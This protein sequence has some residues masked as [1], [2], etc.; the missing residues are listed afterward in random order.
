MRRNHADSLAN[1]KLLLLKGEGG[2]GK[3]HLLCDFAKK[4]VDARLPT[5]L[6]MGQRF[7][8]ED[9]PWVQLTQH[10]DLTGT[11]AEEFVGA[12]ESSAQAADCRAL[13]IIDALNE[14]NGR[15][16]WPAHLSPFL[17]LLEKSPW[18]GVVLSVR[19]SY[20]KLV[21]PDEVRDSA[22]IV[23]HHGFE[24]YEYDATQTFFAHCGLEFPSTPI[25]QPEFSNPL[26][27]KT[28]CKGLSDKGERRIP[29][30]FQG[31]TAV[32][33]LYLGTVNDRLAKDLDYNPGDNLVRDAL[34][35]LSK[36]FVEIE[37]RWLARPVTE[38]IVNELLLGRG[39]SNSLYHGLVTEGVLVEDRSWSTCNSLEEVVSISYDRLADHIIADYLLRTYLDI[40]HPDTAFAEGGS[41]A[42][43]QEERT[44]FYLGLLE[45][46]CIQV[47]EH[48]GQELVRLAPGVLNSPHIG[49]A[50]LE[51]IVWRKLDAFSEDTHGVLN[52]LMQGDR[53]GG[54]PLDTILSVSTVPEHQFN[55]DFLDRWLRQ[56]S[57]PDRDSWWSTYLH[58]VWDTQSPVDRLV[59]W[60]SGLSSDNE[61]DTAVVDLAATTIAWMFTT[62]NR[63]LRDRATKSLVTLLTGRTEPTVRLMDRFSEG[64]DP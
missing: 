35:D 30:G 26:F 49:D 45:A 25:L 27:L 28:L 3:T 18:I 52:E 24:G 9:T 13:V 5:V 8:S 57:M 36:H 4:R 7:L 43:I 63:F 6:L 40:A 44:M 59:A 31:I 11:S 16:I 47:P 19:S 1:A 15:Q 12:L 62:P 54:H 42:F 37:G 39:F 10:L 53:I 48:T 20:E 33:D 34:D 38:R 58:R 32:F 22:L 21:V 2:T 50:F 61:V 14:G 51:S 55:A 23:T 46:L 29:R 41:L 56:Y 60:A 64:D 17:T